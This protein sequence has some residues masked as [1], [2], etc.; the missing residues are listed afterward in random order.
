MWIIPYTK[1]WSTQLPMNIGFVFVPLWN[2]EGVTSASWKVLHDSTRTVTCLKDRKVDIYS[3]AII[4]S[5]ILWT[6][7]VV[8]M[9]LPLLFSRV[10]YLPHLTKSQFVFVRPT[11]LRRQSSCKALIPTYWLTDFKRSPRLIK[12][13]YSHPRINQEF[14]TNRCI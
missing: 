6:C 12:W 5:S 11:N 13:S 1:N 7:Y 10:L 2:Y 14:C 9:D 3:E 8:E 4:T